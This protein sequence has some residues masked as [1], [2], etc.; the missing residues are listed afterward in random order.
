MSNPLAQ[1]AF[2]EP[3]KVII[4]SAPKECVKNNNNCFF[5][6][7]CVEVPLIT[8]AKCMKVGEGTV[9]RDLGGKKINVKC[10]LEKNAAR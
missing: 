2:P 3:K 9:K 7:E 4:S 10:S 8:V 5:F 6:K 1:S